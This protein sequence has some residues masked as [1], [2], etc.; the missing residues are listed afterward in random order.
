M[1]GT[2]RIPLNRQHRPSLTPMAIEIFAQM[3]ACVCDCPGDFD[4]TRDQRCL[5]CQRYNEL[6]RQLRRELKLKIWEQVVED[7]AAAVHPTLRPDEEAR[8]RWLA[9]EA[10]LRERETVLAELEPTSEAHNPH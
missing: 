10:A 9:L 5:D 7:P 2:K 3:R 8:Q 6:E 1:S 4:F